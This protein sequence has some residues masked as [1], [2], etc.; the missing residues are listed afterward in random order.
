MELIISDP[1]EIVKISK[2]LS[3]MARVNILRLTSENPLDITEL[4]EILH[5]SK[6]NV[7]NHVAELESTGLIEIN[8]ENGVKGIRKVIKPKY[9]KI[10]ILLSDTSTSSEKTQENG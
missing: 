5:M 10:T 6:G 4:S 3:V 7:S 8:Y 1:E 9:E 2:T